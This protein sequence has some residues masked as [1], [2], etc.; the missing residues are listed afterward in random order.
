MLNEGL[1]TDNMSDRIVTSLPKCL[2]DSTMRGSRESLRSSYDS[3][4]GSTDSLWRRPVAASCDDVSSL[5]TSTTDAGAVHGR[6]RGGHWQLLKRAVMKL[7]EG[8]SQN[9]INR[10]AYRL[11]VC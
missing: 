6:R 11:L 7:I 9:H 2:S 5:S 8:H 4:R 3:L 10:H 1:I